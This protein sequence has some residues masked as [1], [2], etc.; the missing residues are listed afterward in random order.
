MRPLDER[1]S[2][3]GE[4]QTRGIEKSDGESRSIEII[5]EEPSTQEN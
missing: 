5:D 3:L 2:D 4:A 1:I